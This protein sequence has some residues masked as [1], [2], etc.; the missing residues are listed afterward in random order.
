MVA[1][2][3]TVLTQKFGEGMV[4]P[5]VLFAYNRPEHTQ[6]VFEALVKNKLASKSKLYVFVDA[7]KDQLSKAE[8]K[9]TTAVIHEH[10]ERFRPFDVNYSQHHKGLARSVID[11]LN[12]VFEREDRAIVLEDDIVVTEN[13]LD[14]MNTQLTIFENDPDIKSVCGYS[15]KNN[16]WSELFASHRFFS[17]GW[18]TWKDRWEE[19][20]FNKRDFSRDDFRRLAK[21]NQ[22]LPGMMARKLLGQVDSW[23]VMA[24]Y[25]WGN[26]YHLFPRE[27]KCKNIGLGHGT[28]CRNA[29]KWETDT[30]IR[31]INTLH[32]VE[33]QNYFQPSR[34]RKTINWFKIN[35]YLVTK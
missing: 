30:H 25:F 14:W 13:Y 7:G 24:V 2:S 17:W 18:G 34:I 1:L 20:D 12:Y 8:V 26:G 3:E 22:D 28:N 31:F 9:Y 15:P 32:H 11:G 6:R 27:S 21:I 33:F 19:I 35:Y 23:A 10:Q 29:E 16:S 4:A 5:I